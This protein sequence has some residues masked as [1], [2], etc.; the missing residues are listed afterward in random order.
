MEIGKKLDYWQKNPNSNEKISYE[1]S[2][3]HAKY[4]RKIEEMRK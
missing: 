1:R 3:R 2:D 4:K